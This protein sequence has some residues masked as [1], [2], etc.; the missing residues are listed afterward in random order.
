MAS[1]STY[2][3]KIKSAVYGEE[4]RG[5]IYDALEAMNTESS[6]AIQYASTAKDSAQASATAAQNSASTATQK[7]N[8]AASSATAAKTSETN[9]KTSETKATQKATEA[10]ASAAAAKASEVGASNS[11]TIA[12]QKAGE[13]ADSQTA[14]ALSEVEAK[15]AAE[16]AKDAKTDTKAFMDQAEADKIAADASRVAAEAARDAASTSETNARNS[17][18]TALNASAE[19]KI[20]KDDAETAAKDALDAKV[21]AELAKI[22]AETAKLAAENAQKAAS[23]SADEAA[24]SALS[25]QQYSGKPPM[26]QDGTWWVWDA[27]QQEYIDTGIGCELVGPIGIGVKDIQLTKGDHTPGTTDIY[28]ITLTND[29]TYN[30]SVYNGRNGTGA[31]D[32]LGIW[33]DLVIPAAGWNNGEIT[34]ADERLLALSTHKYFLSASQASREEFLDCNVQP[35]DITTTGFITFTNDT[36][37][38]EDLTVNIIRFELSAN[39][40]T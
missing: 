37:P 11:A 36:D 3:Q 25:A 30:I 12:T 13:A 29:S 6:N 7:A 24:A 1:I 20:A 23:D 8:A 26:A 40:T 5:S 14:A 2:L 39:G 9:A 34:I 33:F 27:D 4:V 16:Q 32:V 28:T 17:A 31:G 18:N 22:D 10:A 15:A 21:D 35:K 38:A 19:A